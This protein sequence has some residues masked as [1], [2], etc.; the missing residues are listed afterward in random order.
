MLFRSN[1]GRAFE[2]T[3]DKQVVWSFSNPHRAGDARQFIATIFDL[4][5]LES[6]GVPW[7]EKT[8]PPGV[9]AR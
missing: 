3:P 1:A 2:I 5:R 7:L 6:P 4:M 9:S 8:P